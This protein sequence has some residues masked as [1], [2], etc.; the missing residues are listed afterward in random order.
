ML[1]RILGAW[2]LFYVLRYVAT[3]FYPQIVDNF[4][5]NTTKNGTFHVSVL[6]VGYESKAANSVVAYWFNPTEGWKRELLDVWFSCGTYV[7]AIGQIGSLGLFSYIL[8]MYFIGASKHGSSTNSSSGS[9]S[10][11]APLIPGADVPL[12]SLF[13][14][15]VCVLL[16]LSVHE[17]GHAAAACL[18]RLN[19]QG[20]GVFF[21]FIFP[22][23][24]VRVEDSIHY[25]PTSAQLRIYSAGVWHN[26]IYALACVLII[27]SGPAIL[28]YTIFTESDTGVVVTA[29]TVSSPLSRALRVGD[30]ISSINDE[31]I[32]DTE[33]FHEVLQKI[34][35]KTARHHA[36][37]PQQRRAFE[38]Y[39]GIETDRS[40][41][42]DDSSRSSPAVLLGPGFC[43]AV[44][45]TND[46]AT[47]KASL[48][49][50]AS[51]C[52]SSFDSSANSDGSED[53]CFAF[54][55]QSDTINSAREIPIDAPSPIY[56]GLMCLNAR[57][58][59]TGESSGRAEKSTHLKAIESSP[60]QSSSA[61]LDNREHE[62][63]P[64]TTQT[65]S[66]DMSRH[67]GYQRLRKNTH[68]SLRTKQGD[69]QRQASPESIEAKPNDHLVDR[70]YFFGTS[71]DH[72]F[73]DSD[74]VGYGSAD[75]FPVTVHGDMSEKTRAM[76]LR[77]VSVSPL[78][79][80]RIRLDDDRVVVVEYPA[81]LL[82][83]S[84]RVSAYMIA[85]GR[86]GDY[87]MSFPVLYHWLLDLP[88]KLYYFFYL[89]LQLNLSV[90]LINMMPS[91][92]LD[93]G[94][95]FPQF[96]KIIFSKHWSSKISDIVVAV[97]TI[98][99]ALNVLVLLVPIV[100]QFVVMI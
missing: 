2:T 6:H 88:A 60:V 31:A 82:E 61:A 87:I 24:Y 54:N 51:C 99:V 12:D 43:R 52:K 49:Y 1:E 70:H 96:A 95:A 74:C 50:P 57:Q 63:S 41:D 73:S 23:A 78:S 3:R 33:H 84:I 7:M 92:Y 69:T 85:P 5:N 71:P 4:V 44:P 35:R 32:A 17:I 25:L 39:L 65:L 19:I 98:I 45:L 83:A 62:S 27:F 21:A 72:C 28:P 64:K 89:S 86:M 46:A 79:I 38:S 36:I 34:H 16:V 26:I 90:A 67:A 14:F 40:G 42:D 56:E 97:G 66:P 20:F 81:A 10:I 11:I 15:W 30:V 37:S 22:G 80:I 94:L 59:I 58:T 68:N 47:K 76:C 9:S 93:G 53:Y 55:D 91:K 8:S 75:I 100:K 48:S 77:P 13:V 18:E 29:V